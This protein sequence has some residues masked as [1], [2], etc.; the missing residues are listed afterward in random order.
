[1]GQ[2]FGMVVV[3]LALLASVAGGRQG[4][5]QTRQGQTIEGDI[6]EKPD[7]VV[8][9]VRGIEMEVQR[10]DITSLTYT[11]DLDEQYR[12]RL[13]GLESGDVAGRLQV[14]RWAFD[15]RRYDLARDAA[16]RALSID[17]NSREAVDFLQLI[18]QQQQLEQA[19]GRGTAAP[20]QSGGQESAGQ[21]GA[22]GD[23]AEAS[24]K[25]YLTPEQI[26]LIKQAELRQS[27]TGI[28]VS[29]TNNVVQRFVRAYNQNAREFAALR[30][31]DQALAILDEADPSFHED[32]KILNDPAPLLE[33]RRFVQPMVL[34]NCAT[35]QCHAPGNNTGFTL[36]NDRGEAASYTNFYI[37]QQF[38]KRVETPGS[39]FGSGP[40]TRRMIDRNQ[41]QMALLVQYGL[42]TDVAD[43]PHPTAVGWRPL[44]RGTN[45]PRY[46]Q[47]IDWMS[48]LRP[49]EPQ[50]G[51]DFQIP[52][53]AATT[54]P[55]TRP[56]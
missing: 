51:I 11:G 54:R 1:M 32:V 47:T 2:R 26:N 53:K 40:V 37:M 38:T 44:F 10:G 16:E 41:P 50:Y 23:R 12:Q 14:G 45:D 25:N 42:P 6:T 55:A 46:Q 36:Y 3:V 21:E 4:V 30:P 9:N 56:R 19:A 31:I 15:N 27:D 49:V 35:S 34:Q 29:F 28:R 17:P 18:R 39:A 43:S 24:G 52:G 48:S 33:F 5:V 13:E 7:S 8:I 20:G 22:P